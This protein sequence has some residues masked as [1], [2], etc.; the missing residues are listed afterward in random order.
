MLRNLIAAEVLAARKRPSTWTLLGVWLTMT[1]LFGYLL[2]YISYTGGETS[3]GGDG[4]LP[5][6]A[7]LLSL[8]PESVTSTATQ[9]MPVFGGAIALIFGALLVGS[10]YGW[11]VVK[12]ALTQRAGRL[13]HL[14]ASLAVVVVAMLGAVLITVAL[15]T[16]ASLVIAS[17]EG[18]AIE[19]PALADWARSIGAGWLVLTMWSAGGVALATVTR[20]T[21]LSVGLGLVWALVLENLVRGIAGSISWLDAVQD[22]LPGANAGSLVAA[23]IPDGVVID[24]PGIVAVVSGSR[25]TAVL[26]SYV[27]AFVGVSAV[28]VRRRDVT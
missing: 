10:P 12:T 26:L 13:R 20:G 21:A 24:T 1:M 17:A 2:P 16:A 22:W 8:L 3:F 27:V 5:P 18:G 9:G 6:E 28:L 4:N 23:L 7:V 25:A 19:L 14:A 15:A 11:G